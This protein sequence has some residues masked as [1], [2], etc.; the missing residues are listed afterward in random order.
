MHRQL[1]LPLMDNNRSVQFGTTLRANPGPG[2]FKTEVSQQSI[3]GILISA[4]FKQQIINRKHLLSVKFPPDPPPD[5]SRPKPLR[6]SIVCPMDIL[7][8]ECHPYIIN[9]KDT[10]GV[11]AAAPPRPTEPNVCRYAVGCPCRPGLPALL[12]KRSHEKGWRRLLKR[13][14]NYEHAFIFSL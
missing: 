11:T 6:E 12:R 2:I 9:E 5:V 1:L 4:K 13:K 8:Q 10:E 7:F 14:E 3:K